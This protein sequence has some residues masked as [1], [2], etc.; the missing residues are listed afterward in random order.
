LIGHLIDLDAK[1]KIENTYI[2]ILADCLLTCDRM[3]LMAFH[4]IPELRIKAK[5][6]Y[7]R[8][9]CVRNSTALMQ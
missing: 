9:R 3:L 2:L 7:P 1:I 4:L 8:N 6:P 5:I